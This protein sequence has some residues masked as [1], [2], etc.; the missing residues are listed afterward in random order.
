MNEKE[1]FTYRAFLLRLWNEDPDAPWRLTLEHARSGERR[2]FAT[3][4]QLSAY[5]EA[6]IE[7]RISST[8]PDREGPDA[9]SV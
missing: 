1:G 6:L 7:P 5:L 9:S 2:H 3:V 8:N 4:Q